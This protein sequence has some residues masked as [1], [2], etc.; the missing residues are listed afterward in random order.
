MNAVLAVSCHYASGDPD[1]NA[2]ERNDHHTPLQYYDQTLHYVQKAMRYS[3]YQTSQ[4]LL[5]T[6]LTISIY[7]MLT[8]SRQD[9]DRHL[10]GV[11]WILRSQKINVET[12]GVES[13][14]W[15]AW[16]RQDIWAAFR[17]K[18]RTYTTWQPT[19]SFSELSPHEHATRAI[20]IMAQVVSFCCFEAG[21]SSDHSR[22]MERLD[23]ARELRQ[24]LDDWN[25]HVGVEYTPLP[26][27]PHEG[28]SAF[29][30]ISIYPSCFGKQSNAS[31]AAG[32]SLI[33]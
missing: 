28:H 7:E 16:L 29:R 25:L 26:T 3:S 33:P 4:E 23:R 20:W 18:R 31:R 9:W 12:D 2:V 10:Q 13:A 8:G 15:W 30:P 19:K 17:E 21:N 1:S 11:F 27:K 32:Q 24:M 6:T 22:M 14:V 5:A